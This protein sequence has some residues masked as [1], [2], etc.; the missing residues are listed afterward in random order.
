[1]HIRLNSADRFEHRGTRV[2]RITYTADRKRYI[3]R[4]RHSYIGTVAP[5][6]VPDV[7]KAVMR[8]AHERAEQQQMR[9]RAA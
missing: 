3:L 6:D 5:G 4:G 9:E 8:W 7:D 1:M 2:K